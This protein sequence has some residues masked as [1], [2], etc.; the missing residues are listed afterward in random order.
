[1]RGERGPGF[2]LV[3]LAVVLVAVGMLGTLGLRA[4]AALGTTS[5]QLAARAST[6]QAA[7]ATR[8]VLHAELSAGSRG[9][10][11]RVHAPDSLSLRAYRGAAIVCESV[12]DSTWVVRRSSSREPDPSK[13][14]VGV[15]DADG[16]WHLAKLVSV[17]PEPICANETRLFDGAITSAVERWSVR[18][19]VAPPVLVRLFESGSYHLSGN[20]LRYRRGAGGRQPLTESVLRGARLVDSL[21]TVGADVPVGP[22]PP[23]RFVLARTP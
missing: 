22:G 8:G 18:P 3:E 17:R 6:V 19:A 16:Q 23:R 20:A 5:A 2:T 12:D 13:D 21:E 7:R 14:S 15:L 1:V 4:Y 9:M 11:W 10:D